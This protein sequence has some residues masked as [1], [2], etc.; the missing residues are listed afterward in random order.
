MNS[1][2]NIFLFDSY[3]EY[4]KDACKSRGIKKELA[5]FIL[6]KGSFLSQILNGNAHLSIDHAFH[7]TEFFK[8]NA[9]QTEYFLNLVQI[10]KVASE[11]LRAFLKKS[12]SNIIKSESKIIKMIPTST[13]LNL[14]DSHT[15]YSRWYYA[16][17]HIL[18]AIERFNTRKAIIDH[19][20]LSAKTVNEVI[21]FLIDKNLLIEDKYKLSIGKARIHI[22]KESSLFVK[23]HEN[24]RVEAI[25]AIDKPDDDHIHYSSIYAFNKK[26]FLKLNALLKKTIKDAESLLTSTNK[27]DTVVVFNLDLF[28]IS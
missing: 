9:K 18:G 27:E 6:V 22:P 19:L 15:Y 28:K 21:Q 10:E 12:N 13:V 4:L 5:E 26:D 2:Q 8:L 16:A 3:K 17:I 14:E 7:V 23:N 1:N 11:N 24:W 20:N 25:R